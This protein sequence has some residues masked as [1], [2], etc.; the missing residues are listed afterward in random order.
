MLQSPR[1]VL[2]D[3]MLDQLDDDTLTRVMEIFTKDMPTMG[4][5][6]IG[7]AEHRNHLY[8]RVLHLVN[9]PTIR[10]LARLK[11]PDAR[12][13]KRRPLSATAE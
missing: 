2:I 8:S 13:S 7:R 10:R 5:I 12:K 11:V 9:D 6:H 1:W 3:E 4:V